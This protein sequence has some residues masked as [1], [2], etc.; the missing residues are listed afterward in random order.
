MTI[1]EFKQSIEDGRRPENV[2]PALLAMWCEARGEWSEAHGIVQ[3]CDDRSAAWVHAYLHRKEGDTSNAVYWYS[4]ASRP[5]SDQA[6]EQ[7][8]EEIVACFLDGE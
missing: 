3:A 1:D 8:W 2:S 6:L 7:E 4:R 5:M